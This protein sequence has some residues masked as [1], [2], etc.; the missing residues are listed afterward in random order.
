LLF[1]FFMHVSWNYSLFW[2]SNCYP[3]HSV[4]GSRDRWSNLF[5]DDFCDESETCFCHHQLLR[6]VDSSLFSHHHSSRWVILIKI[7]ASPSF[8]ACQSPRRMCVSRVSV[9]KT[10]FTLVVFR[11]WQPLR[12]SLTTWFKP[13]NSSLIPNM[14]RSSKFVWRHLLAIS[15]ARFR[16]SLN[17]EKSFKRIQIRSSEE[18]FGNHSDNPRCNR[19]ILKWWNWLKTWKEAAEAA[20]ELFERKD[21]KT[22]NIA[23][24]NGLINRITVISST[25]SCTSKFL[26]SIPWT[27]K[28]LISQT[29]S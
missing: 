4:A 29:I 3:I 1:S 17:A 15:S 18:R 5:F 12:P 7:K 23:I 6:T 8:G 10:H 2:L 20:V 25:A 13:T 27:E 21:N 26:W 14:D 28:Q 16:I 22:T 11:W 9:T 19:Q 24:R